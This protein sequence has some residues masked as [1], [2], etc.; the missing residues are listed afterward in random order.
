M[1][2]ISKIK[3]LSGLLDL[4]SIPQYQNGGEQVVERTLPEIEVYGDQLRKDLQRTGLT[5]DEL[6]NLNYGAQ[7]Q[8]QIQQR[9]KGVKELAYNA[10]V[11][12]D[13]LSLYDVGKDVYEGNYGKAAIG[14]GLFF[15]PN[16][17][18]RPL[19]YLYRKG[20]N[21]VK[22]INA[23][24][25]Y[26]Q[27][28]D[29]AKQINKDLIDLSNRDYTE[30]EQ[31]RDQ[32]LQ[33]N[34]NANRGKF[35]DLTKLDED[36][37]IYNLDDI[38][39]IRQVYGIRRRSEYPNIDLMSDQHFTNFLMKK[40]SGMRSDE[41]PQLIANNTGIDD[42]GYRYFQ[43][44]EYQNP[45]IKNIIQSLNTKESIPVFRDGR[46]IE[47]EISINPSKKVIRK[48]LSTGEDIELSNISN[49]EST[50]INI[51]RTYQD[52]IQDNIAYVKEQFPG[53]SPFGSSVGAAYNR[54]PHVSGD[55]DGYITDTDFADQV[56]SKIDKNSIQ[57]IRDGNTYRVDLFNGKFGHSG[58][59]DFNIIKTD[60]NTGLA[61]GQNAEELF[62]QFFP[63]EYRKAY[64]AQFDGKPFVINK[65]PQELIQA[66]NPSTKTILDSFE[67]DFQDISKN[68]HAGRAMA[69]ISY[70][71]PNSVNAGIRAFGKSL[72]GN[73][74]NFAPQFDLEQLSD[75][76]R[77]M[78][79]LDKLQLPIDNVTVAR[80]PRKMQNA[81]EYWYLNQTIRSRGT[82][83]KNLLT[84]AKNSTELERGFRNWNYEGTGGTAMGAGL[85]T[86][87]LG[88]SGLKKD[89]YGHIQAKPKKSLNPDTPEE[90]IYSVERFVG[91]PNYKFTDSEKN[92]INQI[93]SKH[94]IHL[95]RDYNTPE[96]LLV[97]SGMP[98]S[99]KSVNDALY[100]I[101][102]ELDMPYITESETF[103]DSYY[104]SVIR[105]VN[106]TDALNYGSGRNIPPSLLKRK[107]RL[108]QEDSDKDLE[109][110]QFA[111]GKAYG[112]GIADV[113]KTDIKQFDEFM[114]RIQRI[115]KMR[116]HKKRNPQSYTLYDAYLDNKRLIS[117]I[118]RKNK[119]YKKRSDAIS[120]IDKK[121]DKFRSKQRDVEN[122][123][124]KAKLAGLYGAGAISTGILGYL[125]YKL[126]S[127][128]N[129]D[130]DN[131][132]EGGIHIKKKNR[133]KFTKSAKQHGTGVQEYARKVVND[134][135]ATT[136]QKRR[137]QFA[138]NAKKFKH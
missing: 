126:L 93:L 135:N 98:R 36:S 136:L 114:K 35:G 60:P 13:V 87:M 88:N 5:Y 113:S 14:A 73:K 34:M 76:D 117:D 133:G 72:V 74:V 1:R 30:L 27:A 86:V 84:G 101:S 128:N 105:D 57:D 51:P 6:S 102:D 3:N 95:E 124:F 115:S 75:I 70:A 120:S 54:F 43:S 65:T 40:L 15:L 82:D 39:F 2:K 90:F 108:K 8:S 91:S 112:R 129:D 137:A 78:K 132:S 62:R 46:V 38:D 31:L 10:P 121:I 106:E 71:D 16:I 48:R 96:E 100:E 118:D 134:P 29:R 26:D 33:L 111:L 28:I 41:I 11:T 44:E 68:K 17:V 23:G 12:G 83:A 45:Y 130:I 116:I 37:P 58:E 81:I 123:I 25:R 55:I 107:N 50:S 77:N 4:A 122:N 131:Y 79:I 42:F 89:A 97:K 20:K 67:I 18:E 109:Y 49:T 64:A 52:A 53:F 103:G 66:A 104:S 119:V 85:N 125:T 24:K 80:D 127:N 21:I 47:P 99:G 19:K 94:E 61:V 110:I 22:Y 138:I 69:Y 92:K 9:E 59:V 32:K 7:R 63:D 56:L